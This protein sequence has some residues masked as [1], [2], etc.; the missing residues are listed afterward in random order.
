MGWSKPKR[1]VAPGAA[2]AAQGE[3]AKGEESQDAQAWQGHDA[4]LRQ[5]HLKKA[6]RAKEKRRLNGGC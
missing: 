2:V 1:E 3:K 4:I 5:C 6:K